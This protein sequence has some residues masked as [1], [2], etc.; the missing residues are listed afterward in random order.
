MVAGLSRGRV[1]ASST[2]VSAARAPVGAGVRGVT[3]AYVV[4]LEVREQAGWQKAD[5]RSTDFAGSRPRLDVVDD[6]VIARNPDPESA[7]PYLLRLPLPGRAVVL[8]AR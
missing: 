2:Q 5:P 8:K 7:L 3:C 4:L 1:P 6:F